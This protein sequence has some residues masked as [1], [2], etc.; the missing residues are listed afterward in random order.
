MN[1]PTHRRPT[2]RSHTGAAGR[3]EAKAAALA[4]VSQPLPLLNAILLLQVL[5]KDRRRNQDVWII[6]FKVTHLERWFEWQEE[7][8]CETNRVEVNHPKVRLENN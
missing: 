6:S 2:V 8:K 4:T 5:Q 7:E 3:N 1:Q